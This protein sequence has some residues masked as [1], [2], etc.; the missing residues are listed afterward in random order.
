[1]LFPIQEPQMWFIILVLPLQEDS[2]NRTVHEECNQ[3]YLQTSKYSES[4]VGYHAAITTRDDKLSPSDLTQ[5][6][7]VP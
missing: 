3:T 7:W 4:F 6:S 1:M 5:A 2:W